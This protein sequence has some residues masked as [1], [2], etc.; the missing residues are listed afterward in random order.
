MR[1][2]AHNLRCLRFIDK[3][4]SQL[5]GLIDSQRAIQEF[6]LSLIQDISGLAAQTGGP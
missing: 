5:S 4:G 1:I 6:S 3:G 2:R